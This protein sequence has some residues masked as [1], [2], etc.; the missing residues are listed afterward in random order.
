MNSLSKKRKSNMYNQSTL[1]GLAS[2]FDASVVAL[3]AAQAQEAAAQTT[4]NADAAAIT[5]AQAQQATDQTAL[6]AQQDNVATAQTATDAAL[7]ALQTYVAQ[8]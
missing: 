6:A 1:D 7:S 8:I 2:A 4:V 5:A 3:T